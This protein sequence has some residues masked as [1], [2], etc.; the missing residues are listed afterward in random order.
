MSTRSPMP[1]PATDAGPADVAPAARTFLDDVLAGLRAT[2]KAIP[3]KYF[4][5]ERGSRLFDRITR[6]DAYYPTRTE[7]AILRDNIGEIVALIGRGVALVEYGSGS[8]VKTRILLDHLVDPEMY[9]PIDISCD[10]L[11][12]VADRLTARY[13][14]LPILPVCADYTRPFQLPGPVRAAESRVVFFPGSTIGNFDPEP[15]R[16]FLANV[17]HICGPGG[18]LLIGVDL[19]KD[20]AVLHRAY[21]DEEG[22]TAAFNLNLLRRINEELGGDFDLGAFRHEARYNDALGRIEMY[23]IST[24][25]QVVRIGDER[26]AFD[27]GEEIY[28]EASH[29]YSLDEFE[30]LAAAFTVEHVWTDPRSW[31]SVQFLRAR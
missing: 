19:K 5:D 21:N 18:G 28:T 23:L 7:E 26:F 14:E 15:A 4:Y 22:V 1:V 10:H 31:F 17:A 27:A 6:L 16:R 25:P 12:A 2:P 29:K 20:P 30:A 9:V 24:K 8:S 13:P 3:S 11:E